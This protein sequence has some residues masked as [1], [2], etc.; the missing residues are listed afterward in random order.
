MFAIP[1]RPDASE[2]IFGDRLAAATRQTRKS[3]RYFMKRKFNAA[4]G[5]V[6]PESEL[7]IVG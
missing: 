1:R 7:Q 5:A 6:L 4:P 3:S 2:T